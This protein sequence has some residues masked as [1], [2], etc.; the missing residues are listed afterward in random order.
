MARL[1]ETLKRLSEHAEK[2]GLELELDTTGNADELKRLLA[3]ARKNKHGMQ[4]FNIEEL[5]LVGGGGG[6]WW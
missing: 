3:K 2:N 5:E 4:D 6:G 1:A